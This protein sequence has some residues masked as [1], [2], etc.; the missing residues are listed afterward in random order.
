M[1]CNTGLTQPVRPHICLSIQYRLLT[2][3]LRKTKIGVNIPQSRSNRC[4][5]F[6]L[7][8]QRSGLGLRLRNILYS[9]ADSRIVCRHRADIFACGCGTV[10]ERIQTS[11]RCAFDKEMK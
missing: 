11:Q 5:N 8:D 10:T 3:R 9:L 1:D 4:T 7:I 6:Q 2:N